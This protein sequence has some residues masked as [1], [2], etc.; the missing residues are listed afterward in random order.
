MQCHKEVQTFECEICKK[1]VKSKSLLVRHMRT[2]TGK[3][4]YACKL[5]SSR[6]SD[7]SNMKRHMKMH[8]E[9]SKPNPSRSDGSI[10]IIPGQSQIIE[11]NEIVLDL[12]NIEFD[13]I[14]LVNVK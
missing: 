8:E 2:H 9:K 12:T 6:F 3:K 13:Y 11:G 5:C 7:S 14:V 1:N 10:E 4:P